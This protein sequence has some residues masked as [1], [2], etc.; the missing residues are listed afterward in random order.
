MRRLISDA[1]QVRPPILPETLLASDQTPDALLRANL[2]TDKEV[3]DAMQ[4]LA[5]Q[6]GD[7]VRARTAGQSGWTIGDMEVRFVSLEMGEVALR[8][9][10]IIERPDA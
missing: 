5:A 10:V 3:R 6:I 1:V 8:G 9:S 7:T 2:P 4:K